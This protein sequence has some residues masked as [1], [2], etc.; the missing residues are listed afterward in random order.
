[1]KHNLLLFCTLFLSVFCASHG[2]A[3]NVYALSSDNKVNDQAIMQ[4]LSDNDFSVTLGV[5]PSLWDV[6]QVNLENFDVVILNSD[7]QYRDKCQPT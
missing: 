3:S 2:S 1:M 7:S 5:T 4:T 6:S